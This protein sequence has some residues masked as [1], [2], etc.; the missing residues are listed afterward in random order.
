[1]SRVVH[2]TA[3]HALWIN[4]PFSLCTICPNCITFARTTVPIWFCFHKTHI[5]K[6]KSKV[7]LIGQQNK[8][9]SIFSHNIVAWRCLK[10]VP[11]MQPWL[12]AEKDFVSSYAQ[13]LAFASMCWSGW[14]WPLGGAIPP[15]GQLMQA[16]RDVINP[17]RHSKKEFCL[18]PCSVMALG[19]GH[20]KTSDLGNQKKSTSSREHVKNLWKPLRDE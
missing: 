9:V 18:C 5:Q 2:F 6:S 17:S 3:M 4:L 8:A 7:K 19:S 11:I 10:S 1:M 13:S 14:C 12:L 16:C 15:L 20:Y